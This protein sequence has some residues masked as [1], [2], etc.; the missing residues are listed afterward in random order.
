MQSTLRSIR[1]VLRHSG[2]MILVVTIL[3]ISLM[4]VASMV[5]L[6]S[7]SQQ[8][9]ALVHTQVGTTITINDASNDA[10][11]GQQGTSGS[12]EPGSFGGPPK[13][14]PDSVIAR[15]KQIQGIVSVQES[16][17]R[18][19][20]DA[21]LQ[22]T[23]VTAPN[24]QQ[25]NAPVSV[26]GISSDSTTFTIL[27]GITP[28]LVSG[29]NFRSSDAHARVA[30]MSQALAKANQLQVGSTFSVNGS[31]LTL[32]GLYTTGNPLA[33]SSLVL[34]MATMENVF[35]VK[36]VDSVTATAVSYE[37]V[38][39]VASRLRRALGQS[40]NV[41]TQ[42]AQYRNVFSAL[43]VAQQSIQI[44]LVVSLLV[45]AVV[46]VFAVLMLVRERTAEIAILKTIGASHWQVVRQFWLEIL[47]MSATAA[48][49]AVLL[50]MFLGPVI[51]QKFDI[52]ASSLVSTN[53]PPAGAIFMQTVGGPGVTTA[54]HPLSD[55]HLAAA[56][57]NA[58]TLL[59]IV[60]VGMGLALL[61]SLI[62]TWSVSHI[63]PAIVLR[64]A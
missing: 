32:I 2:R 13:P 10:N 60:G 4:F 54:S 42:T 46:I 61:T 29:R 50:L 63:K 23:L 48:M 11:S 62:P 47:T 57:L 56:T 33:D 41:V 39:A 52:D 14:I 24:G 35:Q 36:G 31:T 18:P 53:T 16:L 26:T 59:I 30:L 43:R 3:G 19:D 9:L 22:G 58:Q 44:A 38:E 55:V 64:K 51:A 27:Q 49:L 6:S 40:F 34:P 15:I 12:N 1:N 17:E 21:S 20:T 37:Q 28:T 8:E 7:N 45:A 5:S 25:V